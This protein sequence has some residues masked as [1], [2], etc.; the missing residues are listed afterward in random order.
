MCVTIIMIIFQIELEVG[1]SVVNRGKLEDV[2]SSNTPKEN[3]TH[4]E[5]VIN[6]DNDLLLPDLELF[7]KAD[8]DESEEEKEEKEEEIYTPVKVCV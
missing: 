3:G 6:E 7:K 1:V 8:S 2:K 4:K 5:D